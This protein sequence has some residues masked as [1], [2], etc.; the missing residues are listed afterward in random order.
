M[1][2]HELE[3]PESG[4]VCGSLGNHRRGELAWSQE[5]LIVSRNELFELTL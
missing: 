1:F 2:V 4:E 3:G 5:E